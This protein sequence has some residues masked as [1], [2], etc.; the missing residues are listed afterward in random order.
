[1]N[2]CFGCIYR[3]ICES[4]YIS[5]GHPLSPFVW[6]ST[7][8]F[9]RIQISFGCFVIHVS[10]TGGKSLGFNIS[11]SSPNWIVINAL[12]H[13][14]DND[15]SCN[16]S[17]NSGHHGCGVSRDSDQF[18]EIWSPYRSSNCSVGHY[19]NYRFNGVQSFP[20]AVSIVSVHFA[21]NSRRKENLA[22][23]IWINQHILLSFSRCQR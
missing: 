3:T 2:C 11:N 10:S 16:L 4:S 18:A 1:M 23:T 15:I 21:T 6:Q 5:N 22:D 13:R 7:V 14:T 20:V 17:N 9:D 19:R 12:S 8:Y